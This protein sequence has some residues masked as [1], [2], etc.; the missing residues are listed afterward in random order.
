M[1]A[2]ILP[3]C[4]HEIGTS[5]Q[6]TSSHNFSFSSNSSTESLWWEA[7]GFNTP[8]SKVPVSVGDGWEP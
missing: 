2:A 3:D 1:I 8:P 4:F 7:T 6:E 5:S